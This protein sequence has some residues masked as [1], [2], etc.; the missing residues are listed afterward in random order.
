MENLLKL[1]IKTVVIILLSTVFLL[2]RC[3]REENKTTNDRV[4]IDGKEYGVIKRTVDTVYVP[5]KIA[6]H[7]QGSGIKRTKINAT[8]PLRVD[9][10]AVINDYFA[11][12]VFADTLY[13]PDGMGFVALQDTIQENKILY[14][15]WDANV[16]KITVKET[17]VVRDEAKRQLYIGV[18]TTL[19]K[20]DLF[21]SAGAGLLYKTKRDMIYQLGVGVANNNG[22]PL[23]PYIGGGMY[24]KIKLK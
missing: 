9:T 2:D 15:V 14:R 8:T 6:Q 5:I 7:K 18:N 23:M 22:R 21:G 17:I 10:T 4:K 3:Q 16:N 11:K 20:E 19:N 13:L 24:W 12:Y 1:D